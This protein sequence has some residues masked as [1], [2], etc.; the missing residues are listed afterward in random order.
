MKNSVLGYI[1]WNNSSYPITFNNECVQIGYRLGKLLAGHVPILKEFIKAHS[2][3]ELI[4]IMDYLE[5]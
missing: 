4:D 2:K 1:S 5:D 3:M